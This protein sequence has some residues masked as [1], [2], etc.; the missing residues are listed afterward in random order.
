MLKI[1]AD[2]KTLG[3]KNV[4]KGKLFEEF[5][6]KVFSFHGYEVEDTSINRSGMEIDIEGRTRIGRTKLYAECKCYDTEVD[7]PKLQA[8]FGKYMTSW[9][10]ERKSE[11]VFIAIPDINTHAKGFY[12]EYCEANSEITLRILNESD[13]IETIFKSGLATNL[14][15]IQNKIKSTTG[16]VAD[17]DVLYTSKGLFIIQYVIS[18]GSAFKDKYVIFD[19]RGD[20][21]T[22]VES[23]Q[24]IEDI[25]SEL[26]GYRRINLETSHALINIEQDRLEEVVTVRGSSSCFEYQF[27]SSP[28]YFVGRQEVVSEI[29]DFTKD[30]LEGVNKYRGLLIEANSGWGKSS[31]VLKL[32][33]H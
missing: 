2:S 8:F 6:R 13:V 28:E 12:K 29:T 32:S 17:Y 15:V 5:M 16:K 19:D 9:F 4:E 22:E 18:A 25:F 23:V 21:I 27:P 11:G 31:L 7:S 30:L 20:P 14:S 3:K 10:K 26:S 24:F 33:D 1:L